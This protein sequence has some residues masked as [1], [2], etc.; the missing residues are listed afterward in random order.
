MACL[1]EAVPVAV[2]S[3]AVGS[4]AVDS[5]AAT[6][7]ARPLVVPADP[8]AATATEARDATEPGNPGR[9]R[10]GDGSTRPLS[11]PIGLVPAYR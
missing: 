8:V 2:G 7:A 1:P 9:S 5:A 3:V 4:V 10:K 11:H 6:E